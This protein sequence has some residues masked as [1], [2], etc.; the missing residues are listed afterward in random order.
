MADRQ[1]MI[2]RKHQPAIASQI[3]ARVDVKE[4]TKLKI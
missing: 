2:Q 3:T 1:T 4:M